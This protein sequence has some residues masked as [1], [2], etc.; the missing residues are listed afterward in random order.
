MN[1]AD[2]AKQ[3]QPFDA[4]KGLQEELRSREER[5]TRVVKKEI[6]EERE[7]QISAELAKIYKRSDVEIT[8]YRGGHYY[9]LEGTVL[10][11]ND[12]YKY[13]LVGQERIYYTDIYELKLL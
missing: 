3:F 10:E 6:S 11:K 9:S 12:V 8:F 7:E 13:L 5:R 1:R 2:R 4:L